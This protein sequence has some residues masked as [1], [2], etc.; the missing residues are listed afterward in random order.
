MTSTPDEAAP[1]DYETATTLK[2]GAIKGSVAFEPHDHAVS[3]PAR[4]A[5]E[6]AKCRLEAEFVCSLGA[7]RVRLGV[8]RTR[9]RT[10]ACATDTTMRLLRAMATTCPRVHD[11]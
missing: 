3:M 9:V 11:F 5:P 6:G 2:L 1:I 7:T 4:P 10:F 8:T